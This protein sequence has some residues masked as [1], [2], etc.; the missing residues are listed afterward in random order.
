MYIHQ[1]LLLTRHHCAHQ[2]RS[3]V[4]EIFAT[5]MNPF[6]NDLPRIRR[7]SQGSSA[8]DNTDDN[9]DSNDESSSDESGLDYSGYVPDQAELLRRAEHRRHMDELKRQ[10]ESLVAICEAQERELEEMQARTEAINA[11]TALRRAELAQ[12]RAD[13]ARRE[14]QARRDDATAT[15]AAAAVSGHP[16]TNATV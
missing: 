12:L 16:N 6:R 8:S 7:D 4:F 2:L 11:A 3:Y 5:T 15:P 13:R 1:Q 10:N 9:S 14:L